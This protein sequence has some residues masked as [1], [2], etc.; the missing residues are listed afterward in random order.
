MFASLEILKVNNKSKQIRI[1]HFI[2]KNEM[3]DS[4]GVW[5]PKFISFDS[6]FNA[7]ME[8]KTST[9]TRARRKKRRQNLK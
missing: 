8:L 1:P 5:F 6:S 9:R 4:G 3:F 7:Q 2:K